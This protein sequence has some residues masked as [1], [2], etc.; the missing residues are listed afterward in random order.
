MAK[1]ANNVQF[2][3]RTSSPQFHFTL[4]FSK[5]NLNGIQ[6]DVGCQSAG[7]ALIGSCSEA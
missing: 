2:M 7:P 6:A 5:W 3:H 1:Q 4:H